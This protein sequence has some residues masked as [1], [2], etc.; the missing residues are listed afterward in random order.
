MRGRQGVRVGAV[1]YRVGMG[2]VLMM[3]G[4]R[5]VLNVFPAFQPSEHIGSHRVHISPGL[6]RSGPRPPGNG[7]KGA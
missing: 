1:I 3:Q 4:L 2:W 6:T 5:L 7:Q